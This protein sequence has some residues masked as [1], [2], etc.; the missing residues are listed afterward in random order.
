MIDFNTLKNPRTKDIE[1]YIDFDVKF[2]DQ[3]V[4]Y[5][6]TPDDF[7]SGEIYKS[8][9]NG[10]VSV[11]PGDEYDWKDDKWV[12]RSEE[13]KAQLTLYEQEDKS[14]RVLMLTSQI[15]AL[16]DKIEFGLSTD[17]EQD[18][19]NLLALRKERAML[20]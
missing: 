12:I 20:V 17:I 18:K 13:Q 6:S 19:A 7:I 4:S 8:L 11:A 15:N 2:G 3:W 10:E 14:Q 9:R 1:K 16:A 5:T